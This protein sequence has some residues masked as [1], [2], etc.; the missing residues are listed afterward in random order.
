MGY[1]ESMKEESIFKGTRGK[2][3][4]NFLEKKKPKKG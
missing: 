2:E 1:G 3:D 4:F